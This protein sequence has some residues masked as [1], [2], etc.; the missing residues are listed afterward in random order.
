MIDREARKMAEDVLACAIDKDYHLA[1]LTM[2]LGTLQSVIA[3]QFW[4]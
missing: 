3:R 1:A 4:S 2:L